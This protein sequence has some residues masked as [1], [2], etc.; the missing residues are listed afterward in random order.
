MMDLYLSH[1][2]QF[3]FAVDQITVSSE[4]SQVEE[5]ASFGVSLNVRHPTFTEMRLQ[6]AS[7]L[8]DNKEKPPLLSIYPAVVMRYC[9]RVFRMPLHTIINIPSICPRH[10]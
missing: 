6:T 2:E 9:S 5:I 1:K 8:Y 7:I 3:L 4:P 10:L